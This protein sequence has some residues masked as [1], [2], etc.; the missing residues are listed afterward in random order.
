MESMQSK[1]RKLAKQWLTWKTGTTLSACL[2][3]GCIL[4]QIGLMG[5]LELGRL[6]IWDYAMRTI[7]CAVT[8]LSVY[9]MYRLCRNKAKYIRKKLAVLFR[10]EQLMRT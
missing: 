9:V 8:E 7:L 10:E 1:Q 4:Y 6:E 5:A 2:L 3:T